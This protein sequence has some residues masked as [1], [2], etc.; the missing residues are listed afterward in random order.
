M[1]GRLHVMVV[2]R[3]K[4][5]GARHYIFSARFISRINANLAPFIIK[6]APCPPIANAFFDFRKYQAFPFPTPS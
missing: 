4:V 3:V 5:Y 6:G 2:D 1:R